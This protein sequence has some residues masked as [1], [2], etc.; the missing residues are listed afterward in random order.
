VVLA[1]GPATSAPNDRSRLSIAVATCQESST[2]R[3]R[4]PERHPD[5]A[6]GC[7]SSFAAAIQFT[8][9]RQAHT[10]EIVSHYSIYEAIRG[11]QPNLK[12]MGAGEGRARESR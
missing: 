10:A 4:K 11:E 7:S 3:T 1:T 6:S 12:D 2:T 9:R 8:D 5:S